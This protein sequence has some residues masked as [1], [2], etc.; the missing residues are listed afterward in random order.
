MRIIPSWFIVDT[1]VHHNNDNYGNTKN[2]IMKI[3]KYK[4]NVLTS[5]N[6]YPLPSK[7]TYFLIS[8]TCS[9]SG[10]QINAIDENFNNNFYIISNS[11]R[12]FLMDKWP[13]TA[14][15]HNK[16][17][18]GDTRKFFHELSYN[19][20]SFYHKL[21]YIILFLYTRCEFK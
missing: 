1:S 15:F 8:L 10:T 18:F 5:K 9:F 21:T 11:K 2:D 17:T 6:N 16:V 19:W 4:I 14:N 12:I 7:F 3:V 20:F 13:E